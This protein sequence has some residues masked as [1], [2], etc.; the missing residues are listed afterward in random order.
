M[1]SDIIQKGVMR[2]LAHSKIYCTAFFSNSLSFKSNNHKSTGVDMDRRFLLAAETYNY[3]YDKYADKL[4]VWAERFTKLMPR[5][6]DI[7][8]KA[9]LNHWP[10]EQLADLFEVDLEKAEFL[11]DQYEKA[12]QIIDAPTP[13]E[14]FRRG[15]RHSIYNALEEGLKSELDIEKLVIQI[16]Y[17]AADLSYLLDLENKKLSEYSKELR[18]EPSDI[19]FTDLD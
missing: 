1:K 15:V 11:R 13:A 8:E 9:E 16:C 5:D 14:S 12:K 6:I 2:W 4:E 7:L 3:S 10:L 17:R 18:S 19:N